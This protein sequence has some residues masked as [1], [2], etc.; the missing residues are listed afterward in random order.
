MINLKDLKGKNIVVYDLEI[1]NPIGANGVSWTDYDRMGISVGCAFDYRN[2]SYSVY[3]D[4]NIHDLVNRLNEPNT[5]LVGFN[6]TGFDNK[7]LR[8]DSI[9][10]SRGVSLKEELDLYC[11]DLL[12]VSRVGAGVSPF[13]KGFKLQDHLEA[14]NLPFKTAEGALAPHWYQLGK[15]GQLISYC[16]NDVMTERSLFEKAL[17]TGKMACAHNT[18]GYSVQLPDFL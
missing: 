7:L 15:M 17:E 2:M 18:K 1:K 4:D 8:G 9:L 11:Y 5:M 12:R 6:H 10:T 14:M 3:L 16:L 13:Q